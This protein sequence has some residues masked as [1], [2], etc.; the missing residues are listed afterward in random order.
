V[1]N[2]DPVEETQET[3]ETQDARLAKLEAEQAEQG[4]KLDQILALI[5]GEGPAHDAAEQHTQE[6]LDSSSTIAEQVR[7]AVEQVGAEKA[8]READEAH[9]ADHAALREQR[10]K[11]PRESASGFRGRL[12]RAMYGGDQ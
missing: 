10:E 2:P 4:G 5:K 12:Q 3:Q 6:R 1:G 8:Q 7:K 9:K 11:P